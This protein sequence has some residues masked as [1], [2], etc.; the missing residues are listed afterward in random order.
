[1][2]RLLKYTALLLLVFGVSACGIKS[3]LYL[4]QDTESTQQSE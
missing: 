3:D 2:A 1:M 4:P